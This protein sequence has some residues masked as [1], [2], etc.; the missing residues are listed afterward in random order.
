MVKG[1]NDHQQIMSR[2]L[3]LAKNGIF[4]VSPNPMV[5]CVVVGDN[6]VVGEG[7]HVQAGGDH[8]EIAALRQAGDRALGARAYV[9]LEPCVHQGR[10]GPCVDAII[11]SGL[12]HV[13]VAC[14]D[15]NPEV[16]GAGITALREAG[17][18][19]TV[20]ILEKQARELNR[21]FIK[22]HERGMPWV[23]IKVATSLDGRT[24]MSSGE[25]KWITSPPARTDVQKLR[26]KSCAV[27]T[28]IGT[29]QLDNPSLDVRLDWQQLGMSEA[30]IDLPIRQPLRV[31]IDSKCQIEASAR[32]LKRPGPALIA[33][34]DGASQRQRANVLRSD[35]IETH[36]FPS[37]NGRVDLESLLGH[38]AE[39]GCNSVMVEAGAILGGAF[40]QQGLLDEIIW[41][42]A[43]KLFGSSA[44][45]MFD[46]PIE[47]IDAHL[48]LTVEDM[49]K[50]G[51]DIRIT[52]RPD[53]DY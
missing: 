31:V 33:I 22:R 39:R 9:T 15:P 1:L 5:G 43:P 7:W 23:T 28:G 53:Q 25:S 48:A 14:R 47:T 37:K 36:F 34:T 2:A 52:L 45:P 18:E 41:Y 46:L 17:I 32:I 12:S 27:I 44:R 29:Q 42:C 51:E 10:T 24:A 3:E 20:G 4:T 8:A 13:I 40:V 35:R 50:I 6:R 21:G 38:L 16:A 11:K 19:V 26:A 30:L 49:C